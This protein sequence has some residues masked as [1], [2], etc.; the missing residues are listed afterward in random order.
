MVCSR[1]ISRLSAHL[2]LGRVS[3]LPERDR[4]QE[5]PERIAARQVKL[6]PLLPQAEALVHALEHVFLVLAAAD[7]LIQV[8]AGQFQQVAEVPPPDQPGGQVA[9]DRVVRAQELD[10]A[11]DRA[12][13]YHLRISPDRMGPG[14]YRWGD[15]PPLQVP[16][17][18]RPPTRQPRSNLS[19]IERNGPKSSAVSDAT[20]RPKSHYLACLA[21][22]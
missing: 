5:L 13:L 9:L 20:G 21:Q 7:A 14:G 19:G 1:A 4:H 12:F 10:Q 18:S 6:A 22:A 15:S 17:T 16:S 11:G 8:V 2:L 3:R